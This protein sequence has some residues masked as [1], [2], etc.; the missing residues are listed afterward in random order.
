MMGLT[1]G[2][3]GSA[4][5]LA[6]VSGG[7]VGGG[8]L[9]DLLPTGAEYKAEAEKSNAEMRSDIVAI[10]AFL[11]D[12]V[13]YL[14]G[15]ISLDIAS[16]PQS[17]LISSGILNP[18]GFGFGGSGAP[19]G[20]GVATTDQLAKVAE[21]LAN[22]VSA[23]NDR[24]RAVGLFREALS[25]FAGKI[26]KWFGQSDEQVKITAMFLDKAR[27][28][29]AQQQSIATAATGANLAIRNI[30]APPPPPQFGGYQGGGYPQPGMGQMPYQGGMLQAPQRGALPAFGG[31]QAMPMQGGMPGGLR[32]APPRSNDIGV[33]Q[34]GNWF[35]Y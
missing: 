35:Y 27:N 31:R 13:A 24:N 30:P 5:F 16:A 34:D 15:S 19:A 20:S 22:V 12:M 26:V 2:G 14:R 25:W 33:D 6:M 8:G 4:L 11:V 17:A 29:Q 10:V 23:N 1:G 3:L 18:G 21:A 9:I 32:V 28:Q 7:G